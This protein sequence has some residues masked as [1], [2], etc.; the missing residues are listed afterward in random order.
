MED[1][2]YTAEHLL[3]YGKILINNYAR[4]YAGEYKPGGMG[5]YDARIVRRWRD[6]RTLIKMYPGLLR[7]KDLKYAVPNTDLSLRTYNEERIE[8]WR[9]TLRKPLKTVSRK[10]PILKE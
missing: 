7:I 4:A 9:Q 8:R 3:R 1:F 5:T 6:C 2:R 10:I